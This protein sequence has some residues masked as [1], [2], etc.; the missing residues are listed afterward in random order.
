MFKGRNELVLS[1]ATVIEALQ[2]W[3]HKEVLQDDDAKVKDVRFLNESFHVVL[4]DTAETK[5]A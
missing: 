4:D 2:Y 1:R 3:L 5:S